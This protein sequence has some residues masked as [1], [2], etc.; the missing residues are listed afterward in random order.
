MARNLFAK[1]QGAI[2]MLIV[3][4]LILLLALI[5]F[6]GGK[7]GDAEKSNTGDERNA[8]AESQN[9]GWKWAER[10]KVKSAVQCAELSDSNEKSGCEAY[11]IFVSAH[12]AIP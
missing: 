9:R 2:A 12:D 11:V 10:G 4:G 5:N 3:V 1:R 7:L 6:A 8:M